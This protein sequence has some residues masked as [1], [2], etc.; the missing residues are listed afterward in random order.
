MLPR[1]VTSQPGAKR[2]RQEDPAEHTDGAEGAADTPQ[3]LRIGPPEHNYVYSKVSGEVFK[4]RRGSDTCPS[5]HT[6]WLRRSE[7]DGRWVA[8]DGPDEDRIPP[9]GQPIF[10]SG[11]NILLD[12]WHSW[13]MEAWR[14]SES[15]FMTTV[16]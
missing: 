12:G 16:L 11:E 5:G 3:T 9:M 8:H 15:P 14:G 13:R 1:V 2:R 4:C 6:L 7:E 10:T